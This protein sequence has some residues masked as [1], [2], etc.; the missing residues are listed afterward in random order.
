M[1]SHLN[2]TTS[3]NLFSFQEHAKSSEMVLKK[4]SAKKT[5]KTL[6]HQLTFENM[7]VRLHRRMNPILGSVLNKNELAINKL[8]SS[9]QRVVKLLIILLLLFAISWLP[10]HINGVLIDLAAIWEVLSDKKK[11][12]SHNKKEKA[13][14]YT[15]TLIEQLFPI[16]LCLAL[17]N[18][19]TNPVCFIAL[20]Q[21][22]RE[23]FK[24]SCCN[25]FK[26]NFT[27]F[28]KVNM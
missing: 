22:F 14:Q 20:S 16:S 13:F 2:K 18:S 17:A 6:V 27:K 26:S 11:V 23:K 1:R 4:K 9:R 5:A 25:C 19:A 28:K 10:Y 7:D 24:A 12:L 8:I 21:S 3:L 15:Q